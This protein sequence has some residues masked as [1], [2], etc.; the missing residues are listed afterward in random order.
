MLTQR[1][2]PSVAGVLATRIVLGPREPADTAASTS[3]GPCRASRA[4]PR[5]ACGFSPRRARA[6]WCGGCS[7][8]APRGSTPR[9][10][11]LRGTCRGPGRRW[12]RGWGAVAV[13]LG[14]QP[15]E[16]RGGGGLVG[17]GLLEAP[18]LADDR[19]GSGV[20]VDPEGSARELLDVASGGGGHG[21]TITS[22]QRE[23]P[24]FVPRPVPRRWSIA[25]ELRCLAGSRLS[26]S[27][28]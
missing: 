12:L 2:A 13:G 17:A 9:G 22:R 1:A 18:R 14:E 10:R 19:V 24:T 6:Q 20:D 3:S 16:R 23:S 11:R 7:P 27:N 8:R 28:R 26:E 4:S 25:F 5:R 21:V 15:S